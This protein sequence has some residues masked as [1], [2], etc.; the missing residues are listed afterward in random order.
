MARQGIVREMARLLH[1]IWVGLWMAARD[2]TGELGGSL[3]GRF[4]CAW[5][6]KQVMRANG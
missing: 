4:R 6:A 5:E 3:S 2:E 1:R